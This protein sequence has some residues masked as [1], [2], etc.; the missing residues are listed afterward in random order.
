MD[1]R[2]GMKSWV[3][4]ARSDNFLDEQIYWVMQFSHYESDLKIKLNSPD[5]INV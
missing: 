3:Y 1:L 5:I 2:G 4:V